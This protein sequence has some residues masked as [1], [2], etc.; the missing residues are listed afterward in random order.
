MKVRYINY[1]SV[2]ICNSLDLGREKFIATIA[3]YLMYL[4]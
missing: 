1:I 4:I 3:Q 2:S